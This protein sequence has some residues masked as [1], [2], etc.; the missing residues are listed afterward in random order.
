MFHNG[1]DDTEG[2][3]VACERRNILFDTLEDGMSI[4]NIYTLR[5]PRF[6]GDPLSRPDGSIIIPVNAQSD[7][8]RVWVVIND[9]LDYQ[10]RYTFEIIVMV[11]NY[12][13]DEPPNLTAF[14]SCGDRRCQ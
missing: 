11:N 4:H 6:R 8:E 5:M 2:S 14:S 10:G 3:T 7:L 12:P 1:S 13:A 9:L